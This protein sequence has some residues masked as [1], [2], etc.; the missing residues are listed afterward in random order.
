MKNYIRIIAGFLALALGLAP[1]L[2]APVKTVVSKEQQVLAQK[3]LD[4]LVAELEVLERARR[5]ELAQP[6]SE[7]S[8]TTPRSPQSAPSHARGALNLPALF[9]DQALAFYEQ[10]IQDIPQFE[11]YVAMCLAAGIAQNA[12][13]L[14][15][16]QLPKEVVEKLWANFEEQFKGGSPKIDVSDDNQ[17]KPVMS[18]GLEPLSAQPKTAVKSAATSLP[19][20]KPIA[21]EQKVI[22]NQYAKV[23]VGHTLSRGQNIIA[24]FKDGSI[25]DRKKIIADYMYLHSKKALRPET[26]IPMLGGKELFNKVLSL[27]VDQEN[28]GLIDSQVTSAIKAA[29]NLPITCGRATDQAVCT[30]AVSASQ[31]IMDK[32]IAMLMK[33]DFMATDSETLPKD[34]EAFQALQSQVIQILKSH[35]IA[36]LQVAKPV[37]N[38]VQNQAWYRRL[39]S[40]IWN[41]KGKLLALGALGL[42]AYFGWPYLSSMAKSASSL[43]TTPAAATTSAVTENNIGLVS[44][45]STSVP[46]AVKQVT[47]MFAKE[48][49]PLPPMPAI[50]PPKSAP[51]VEKQGW[52]SWLLNAGLVIPQLVGGWFTM[53]Q[54]RD[55]FAARSAAQA[56]EP[57]EEQEEDSTKKA[58]EGPDAQLPQ[59]TDSAMPTEA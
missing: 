35:G 43:I 41:H 32:A 27:L 14:P 34:E 58:P 13:T 54:V 23:V 5:D 57:Q 26:I 12:G 52:G 29:Y 9:N 49:S 2:A 46:P 53:F 18:S 10:K 4:K 20:T 40:G 22:L 19:S 6:V 31:E 51:A 48:M 3:S 25:E 50:L 30:K 37:K 15:T 39:A 47:S 33:Y 24:L 45:G 11:Q 38:Q 17:E 44:Q 36:V 16:S 55:Y 21:Q 42:G 28:V 8:S 7:G 59:L 56:R 1:L